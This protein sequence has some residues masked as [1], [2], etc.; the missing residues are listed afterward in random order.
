LSRTLF[1]YVLRT[2]ATFAAGI[3]AGMLAIFLVVDFV[4]RSK[5]YTGP[6]WVRD[7]AELYGWKALQVIQQLG[8]AAL[9]LGAG[10]AV[11]AL[12]KRGE[13]TAMRSLS[14]GPSILYLPIGL[15]A[16]LSA[17]GLMAFDEG[18]VTKAGRRVDEIQAHRFDRWGD[19]RIY[20]QPKQWFRR[21]DW[22][23]FLRRGDAERGFEEVTLLKLTQGFEL[24]QRID[25]GRM[26]HVESTRWRLSEVVERSFSPDGE[27]PLRNLD[28]GLYDLGVPKSA[29]NIMTGRPEQMRLP[30]LREQIRARRAVGLPTRSF[31]L[32]LHNR[33]AYPLAG[34]PAALLAIGL[35]LRPNRKGHL[36]TALVEGLVVA[37]SLWGMMVVCKALV[38]NDR[39]AAGFAAWA[40]VALLSLL[41]GGL[42]LAHEGYPRGR[43][44]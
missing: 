27:S 10:V 20:Y 36:T 22:V 17:L 41:A 40:P 11:S 5:S 34:V 16:L 31:D 3:F 28:S 2:Y 24:S 4:D 37:M 30:E 13:V 19:W 39:V 21:G 14:L 26:E 32:T 9:M 38:V 29:L 25:A 43:R 12:R 15:C 44:A 23:L 33:F 8:P 7:V 18:L 42:W 1:R 35:A 6:N